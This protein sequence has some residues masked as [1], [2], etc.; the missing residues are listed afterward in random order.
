MGDACRSCG[1][2]IRWAITENGHRAPLDAQPHA[3]GNL[4]IEERNGLDVVVVVGPGS[5]EG[6]FRSHFA[7]CPHANQH[8]RRT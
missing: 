3:E 6:L 5:E 2:P 8:R 7:S 1:A 4:R